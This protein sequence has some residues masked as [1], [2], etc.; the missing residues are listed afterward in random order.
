[1]SKIPKDGTG[2]S[3]ILKGKELLKLQNVTHVFSS[4]SSL[5][6]V[7]AFFLEAGLLLMRRLTKLRRA[8]VARRRL[9]EI[10]FG[11]QHLYVPT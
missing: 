3:K 8:L 2:F 4:A 5:G 7:S 6:S 9:K 10:A 11:I 1:M